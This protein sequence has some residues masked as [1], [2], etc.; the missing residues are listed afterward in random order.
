MGSTFTPGGQRWAV[1]GVTSREPSSWGYVTGV[2]Q[3]GWVGMAG[4]MLAQGSRAH[5]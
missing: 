2:R 5:R 4:A 1:G 3:E